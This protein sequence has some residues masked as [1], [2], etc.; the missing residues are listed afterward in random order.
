MEISNFIAQ[1]I[2]DFEFAF[3]AKFNILDVFSTMQPYIT[4]NKKTY[5]LIAALLT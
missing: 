2:V 5:K 1:F 4:I 3:L